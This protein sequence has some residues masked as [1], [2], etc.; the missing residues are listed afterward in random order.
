MPVYT[1]ITRRLINLPDGTPCPPGQGV[2]ISG[3]AAGHEG[4]K[5]L[6]DSGD[7]VSGEVAPEKL[8]EARMKHEEKQAEQAS[9][10]AQS[11]AQ[12]KPAVPQTKAS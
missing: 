12:A 10:P 7:F 8:E 11:A 2:D 1:N 5:S 3:E 9:K 6:I 4:V